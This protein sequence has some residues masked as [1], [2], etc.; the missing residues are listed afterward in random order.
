MDVH[1]LPHTQSC[2]GGTAPPAG[3]G[4]QGPETGPDLPKVTQLPSEE[5]WLPSA[6][7]G[8]MQDGR[9]SGPGQPRSSVW[10]SSCI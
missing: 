6:W 7:N 10:R 3:T 4:H 1:D 8:Q 5:A 9:P 2:E